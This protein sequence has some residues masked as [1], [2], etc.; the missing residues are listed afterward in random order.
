VKE[1]KA[2]Y[3]WLNHQVYRMYEY[4]FKWADRT[5]AKARETIPDDLRPQIPAGYRLN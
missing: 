5:Q 4:T 1:E 3:A 2:A